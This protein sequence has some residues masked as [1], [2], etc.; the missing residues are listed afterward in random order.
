VDRSRPPVAH[1]HREGAQRGRLDPGGQAGSLQPGEDARTELPRSAN[2][3]AAQHRRHGSG[4]SAPS[5]DRPRRRGVRRADLRTDHLTQRDTRRARYED[6][7]PAGIGGRTESPTA[8]TLHGVPS[9]TGTPNRL[10]AVSTH[11]LVDNQS[12][13][14]V[15]AGLGPD[16]KSSIGCPLVL[17]ARQIAR[18]KTAWA[19]I[20]ARR[21]AAACW[22]AVSLVN[23]TPDKGS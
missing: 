16:I 4:W 10:R 20:P 21:D 11:G 17:P 3:H 7:P 6:N 14:R 2:R 22:F 9:P 19:A 18:R 23:G 15:Q 12:P 5:A 8:E 1:V 13:H